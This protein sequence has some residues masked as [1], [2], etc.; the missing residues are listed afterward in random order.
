MKLEPHE[1]V[2]CGALYDRLERR[3]AFSLNLSDT[4]AVEALVGEEVARQLLPTSGSLGRMTKGLPSLLRVAAKLHRE[5]VAYIEGLPLGA[6][7]AS[8]RSLSHQR[9]RGGRLNLRVLPTGADGLAKLSG[10]A[11]AFAASTEQQ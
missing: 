5:D 6:T 4:A 2:F 3:G 10:I 7:D 9:G 8:L 1:Q 11:E